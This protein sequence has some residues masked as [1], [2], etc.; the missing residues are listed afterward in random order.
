MAVVFLHAIGLDRE[1]WNEVAE[2]GDVVLELPGHGSAPLGGALSMS[3][4]A[5]YVAAELTEPADV[6][7]VSLGGMVALQLALRHPEAV[8]SIVVSAASAASKP[9]IMRARAEKTRASGM[10]GVLDETLTRWFTPEALAEPGHPGVAYA[11]RRL[12]SDDPETFARYWEVIGQHDV[13]AELPMIAAPTTAVGGHRDASV[14]VAAVK[15]MAAAIGDSRLVLI[16]A[17]HI[18]PLGDARLFRELVDEHL[19]WV[20]DTAGRSTSGDTGR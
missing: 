15:E 20:K 3:G 4:L 10:I 8:R 7:G 6:V 9:E 1:L 11:R 19:A 14:P 5:D 12:L 18:P 2:P 16:D 17:A 13:S